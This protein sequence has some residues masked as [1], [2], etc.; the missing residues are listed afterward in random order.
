VQFSFRSGYSSGETKVDLYGDMGV[1][2]WNNMGNVYKDTVESEEADLIIHM[3]DHAYNQGDDDE[4]RGD[5]Y[6]NAFSKA[7]ANSPWMP[8]V[9][10]HEYY[11]GAELK[12]YLDQTWEEWG[13]VAG[14]NVTTDSLMNSSAPIHLDQLKG[15]SFAEHE[16]T[17]AMKGF[18]SATSAVGALLSTGELLKKIVALL[19]PHTATAAHC[20]SL[21]I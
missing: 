1:Y 9:G 6:M 11:A 8:I 7:V 13:P 10:N 15:S 5:G 18:S 19:L 12:R 20:Y 21:T 4:R 14:G 17:G 3:G 16:S 2:S